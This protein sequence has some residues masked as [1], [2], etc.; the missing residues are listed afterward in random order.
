MANE[1]TPK[2][3]A[4]AIVDGLPKVGAAGSIAV[5][6]K[7]TTSLTLL[8]ELLTDVL[9]KNTKE[10]TKN[11]KE[12]A[13]KLDK[14]E[15]DRVAAVIKHLEEVKNATEAL[16][17]QYEDNANKANKER[18]DTAESIK[19]AE[20]DLAEIKKYAQ[21][22][23]K[24]LIDGFAKYFRESESVGGVYQDIEQNGILLR[25]GFNEL[26][27]TAYKLGMTYEELAGHLKKTSPLIARLN[28]TAGNGV[29][30]FES[31]L[32]SIDKSLNLTNSEKV[33]VFENLL[34]KLS[35]D[36]LLRMSQEEMNIEINK[37]AKEMKMLSLATGK[38][39]EI[40]NKENALKQKT[41]RIAAWERAHKSA[42]M[43]LESS[44]LKNDEDVMEFIMTGGAYMSPELLTKIQNDPFAQ[45]FLPEIARLAAMNQLN[46]ETFANV[47]KK[48]QHLS[49][50]K[51]NVANTASF[52]PAQMMA[53]RASNMY[54]NSMFYSIHDLMQNANFNGNMYDQYNS[55]ERQGALKTAGNLIEYGQNL[56]RAKTARRTVLSGGEEGVGKLF[57][58]L[59]GVY[60][61]LASSL[62]WWN[63]ILGGP[64]AT[65]ALVSS[66]GS[67]ALGFTGRVVGD[68]IFNKAVNKFAAAVG[69]MGL[70]WKTFGKL[71]LR[72]GAGIGGAALGLSMGISEI[73]GESQ[74]GK[75]MTNSVLK[76]GFYGAIAGGS[77]GGA[78]YGKKGIMGGAV[79]GA[80]IGTVLAL[81]KN[82]VD[83]WNSEEST[84]FITRGGY[85]DSILTGAIMGAAIGGNF[86][87]IKGA[88]YGA[89]IG[90]IGLPTLKGAIAA[91][92][93][94]VNFFSGNGDEIVDELE[95]K[96]SNKSSPAV[97]A[98]I[99]NYVNGQTEVKPI[100][101]SVISST[102]NQTVLQAE[103]EKLNILKSMDSNIKVNANNSQ[104]MIGLTEDNNNLNLRKYYNANTI[105]K[106]DDYLI[107]I[108]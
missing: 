35:P 29:K 32:S 40:I 100:V 61:G 56:N 74:M 50:Y 70:N 91:F 95:S 15:K 28:G 99:T 18:I 79:V 41:G 20:L 42:S 106:K 13:A 21:R 33:A 10:I 84:D 108:E 3:L 89:I 66:L 54:Q 55:P 38:S 19:E 31:S 4:D 82:I 59:S 30:V 67:Q 9:Q 43:I 12:S 8:G 52:D 47:Y 37:T 104:T 53:A 69:A 65:K 76:G 64:G 86:G 1:I 85:A 49:G 24:V 90:A 92:K 72:T 83:N 75:S 6:F 17:K 7:D 2:A 68:I 80:S 22:G 51:T 98:A 25:N 14:Q 57:G 103:I 16:R 71:L 62:N 48:Y 58:A 77:I 39:V 94:V 26:G 11:N 27:Q 46:D 63:D 45:Q 60:G 101:N 102:P 97:N 105:S 107:T 78:I 88:A 73:F 44:G 96:L 5:G 93:K 23:T 34:D 87:G 81:G 36:Q